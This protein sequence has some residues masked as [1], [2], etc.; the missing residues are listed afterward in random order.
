MGSSTSQTSVTVIDPSGTSRI[1]RFSNVRGVHKQ[2][3]NTG[4]TL[5]TYP[6]CESGKDKLFDANGNPSRSSDYRGN[7]T[8]YLYDL[9]RNLETVR[10]DGLTSTTNCPANLSTYVPAANTRQRKISTTWHAT[11]R[12]PTLVAEFNRSTAYTYDASGNWLTRAVTNI[13]TGATRTWTRSY[14]S[15][16]RVL[17]EMAPEPTSR[18]S[19]RIRI[20]G[21]QGAISA[22]SCSP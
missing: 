11:F 21:A 19:R 17:T 3:T 12:Q 10:L 2:Q 22:G 20:I 5:C 1:H 15:Y 7:R 18:T 14:D 4:T 13:A 16:G 8:C 9:S 6:G